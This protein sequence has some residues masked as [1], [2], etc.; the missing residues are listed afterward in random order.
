MK[1]KREGSVTCNKGLLAGVRARFRCVCGVCSQPLDYFP[2]YFNPKKCAILSKETLRL[3]QQ[4]LP[5]STMIHYHNHMEQ[6]CMRHCIALVWVPPVMMDRVDSG[7]D[8]DFVWT[9]LKRPNWELLSWVCEGNYLCEQYAS[10]Q[11]SYYTRPLLIS[12][13]SGSNIH[14]N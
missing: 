14:F 5:L 11:S 6:I 12:Y 2:G 10:F 3:W 8:R 13:S 1:W 4:L 9:A 7:A